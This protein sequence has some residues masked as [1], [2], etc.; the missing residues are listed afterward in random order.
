MIL[1]AKL[2]AYARE[3]LGSMPPKDL[4]GEIK[5]YNSPPDAV[6]AVMSGVVLLVGRVKALKDCPEWKD[7][8]VHI[9]N[10]LVGECHAFDASVKGKKKPWVHQSIHSHA[11]S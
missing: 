3:L 5:S 10:A 8:R 7:V 4:I 6:K 9:E 11:L 2:M 1:P